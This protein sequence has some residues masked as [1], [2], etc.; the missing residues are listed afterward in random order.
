MTQT[1]HNHLHHIYD[2]AGRVCQNKDQKHLREWENDE[3]QD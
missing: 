2:R 1:E 3:P